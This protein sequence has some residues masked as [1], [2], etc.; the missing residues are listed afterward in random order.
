MTREI[1]GTLLVESSP[2]IVRGLCNHTRKPLYGS[3]LVM[4]SLDPGCY[5]A[6]IASA[7]VICSGGGRTGHMESLCRSRGIPV[8]RVDRAELGAITGHVTVRLDRQSV[9]LGE[10]SAGAQPARSFGVAP[11]DLGSICVVIAAASDVRAT[12]A[13]PTRVEQVTSFFVCEEFIC[14]AAGLSPLDALRSAPEQYGAAIAAELGAIAGELL[15]GQRLVMR[16]LDLRSDDATKITTG[17]AVSQEPNP[18]LGLHGARWL[19]AARNYPLAFRALRAGVR[20]RLGPLGSLGSLG[21]DGT[22][23]LSFAVPFVNDQDEYRQLRRHLDL[24]G[25]TPLSA[26]IE[27]PAAVHSV[28]GFCAAGAHELFVGTK[29]LVQFYLAADRKNHLVASSYR[30]R[31]P[32]VMAGLRHVVETARRAA[33]PVHVFALLADMDYYVRELGPDGF[34]MCTAELQQLAL[35]KLSALLW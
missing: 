22:A 30:T 35:S 19:L 34:M 13:L 28:A 15:P 21:P 18:D 8:L 26:F 20:E 32:A 24:P 9:V 29:D 17:F 2:A 25:S 14:L 10:A 11:A 7:A 3:V 31:H 4:E 23:K 27:T 33:T 5:D 1:P 6:I 16:L 12:N